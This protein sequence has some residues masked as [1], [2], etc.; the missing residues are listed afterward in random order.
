M[1]DVVCCSEYI[2]KLLLQDEP[3]VSKRY[4]EVLTPSTY[5]WALFGNRVFTNVIKLRLKSLGWALIQHD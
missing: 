2:F 4:A 5:E 1:T 3:C